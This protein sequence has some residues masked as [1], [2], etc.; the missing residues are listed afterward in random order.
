M[1]KNAILNAL[2]SII[3]VIFPLVTYPYAARVVGV[4]HIGRVD[5]VAHYMEYFTLLATFGTTTFAI[6]ECAA[7]RDDRRT[8]DEQASEIWT[9][10]LCTTLISLV[11]M[12]ILI[13]VYGR[14]HSYAPIFA[15]QCTS[16]V[17]TTLGADWI[18]VVYE[19]FGYVTVRGVVINI[20]NMVLLFTFVRSPEDYLVYAFLNIA[21]PVFIGISNMF[22]IRR[23]V[24]LRPFFSSRLKE[25]TGRLWPFFINEFSIAIYVGADSIILGIIRG[26]YLV[27]IYSVAVKIYTIVKSVFIA[28]FS[29]TLSRLS[30]HAAHREEDQFRAILSGVIS[31]FI[32]LGIPAMTGM[33]LY[34]EPIVLLVGGDD[35]V[36]AAG[37]LR[38]LAIALIFA[39]FGGIVTN[40]IDV[41]LGFEKVNSR[42]TV[43]ASVEN[44]VLNIPFIFLWDEYG[45]AASTIMAEMTVLVYC[46]VMLKRSGVSLPG[47]ISGR[48]LRDSAVGVLFMIAVYFPVRLLDN[49]VAVIIAGVLLSV[50]VYFGA[51]LILKNPIILEGKEKL[52][53][54][55]QHR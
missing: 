37:S 10:S 38:L 29:V 52:L 50:V 2:R 11:L 19:N 55:L 13:L 34:A 45:A 15:I 6:R 41:P 36:R 26:D 39:V 46:I 22:Y 49:Y 33:I 47:I 43:I 4:E 18:N 44:I 35:Y 23:F 40:C 21:T 31:V 53:N 27:G 20:L 3:A 24:T 25:L 7:V 48:C 1:K 12:V 9:F 8:A 28:I 54:K 17:F 14:L 30:E 16:V 5:Y 32:I 51:I 42:A